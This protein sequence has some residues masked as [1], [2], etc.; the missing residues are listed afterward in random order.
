ML[1]VTVTVAVLSPAPDGLNVTLK[2]QEVLTTCAVQEFACEK[3]LAFAP[4]TATLLTLSGREP[5]LVIATPCAPLVTPIAV[6]EKYSAAGAMNM[7]AVGAVEVPVTVTEA[8]DPGA[9]VATAR[10]AVADPAT[11]GANVT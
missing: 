4:L 6:S 11:V 2:K 9:F 7:T 3:S 10:V 5:P 1:P 8:G